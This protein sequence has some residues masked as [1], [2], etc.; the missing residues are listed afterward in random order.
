MET[1]PKFEWVVINGD[2]KMKIK[3]VF[4]SLLVLASAAFVHANFDWGS[5]WYFYDSDG[6]TFLTSSDTSTVGAFAQLIRDVDGDGIDAAIGTGT[7]IPIGSDDVVYWASWFGENLNDM[8][9]AFVTSPLETVTA[10]ATEN[11]YIFY[12]RIWSDPVS[13][14]S[15]TAS[16]VPSGATYWDAPSYTYIDGAPSTYDMTGALSANVTVSTSPIPEPTVLGLGLIGLVLL[17]SF[18]RK[19]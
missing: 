2:R 15:G 17:R 13:T 8:P 9:G 4:I 19:A 5:S 1:V 7:G 10:T 6:T 16:T 14:W 3:A 11:N 12:A 18:R